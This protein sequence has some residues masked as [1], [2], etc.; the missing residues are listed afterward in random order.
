M[1]GIECIRAW[2]RLVGWCGSRREGKK[3][4]EW[5]K[6]GGDVQ[7]YREV[8]TDQQ[9]EW[10]LPMWRM[11]GDHLWRPRV[12]CESLWCI[13]KVFCLQMGHNFPDKVQKNIISFLFGCQRAHCY[14]G[15]LCSCGQKPPMRFWRESFC[16]LPKEDTKF[17][18]AI[19]VLCVSWKTYE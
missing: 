13:F 6:T 10:S 2:S 5:D 16:W 11:I 17:W 3:W 19:G 8:P 1:G 12:R 4:I 18:G 15:A 9:L 14:N 7:L